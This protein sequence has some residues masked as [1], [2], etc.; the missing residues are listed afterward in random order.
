PHR[1]ARIHFS[2]LFPTL[3]A[4]TDRLAVVRTV[5]HEHAPVHEFGLQLLN[6]GRLFR[7][8]PAA[9]PL[10]TQLVKKCDFAQVSP[11]SGVDCG[12]PIPVGLES[13]RVTAGG[14]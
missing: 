4:M 13:R 10:G 8:G 7:D 5:T 14:F 12:I 1:R 2:D 9:P 11:A 6:T 3:A